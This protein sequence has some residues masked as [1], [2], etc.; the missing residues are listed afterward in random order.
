MHQGH[1]ERQILE[2]NRSG[3][4]WGYWIRGEQ[5]FLEQP[6]WKSIPWALEPAS[7]TA[8]S[9]LEDILCT[10]PSMIQDA[11]KLQD[12]RLKPDRRNL[13]QS[14][15]SSNIF[16]HFSQLNKWRATWEQNNPNSCVK[17]P[18]QRHTDDSTPYPITI[19]LLNILQ[20]NEIL[21]YNATLILSLKLGIKIIGRPFEE[22]ISGFFPPPSTFRESLTSLGTSLDIR[23]VAT[24]MCE[25]IEYCLTLHHDVAPSFLFLPLSV[26]YSTFEPA[27]TQAQWLNKMQKQVANWSGLVTGGSI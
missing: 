22:Y 12:H 24:E 4:L 7:K 15:L 11:K 16:E 8:L 9:Y 25:I 6:E 20:A 17:I 27:S 5:C 21:F 10:I 23:A 18:K 2:C 26:A 1:I 3:I 19:C 14:K 13:I